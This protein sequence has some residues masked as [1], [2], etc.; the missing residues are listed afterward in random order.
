M[1]NF[2]QKVVQKEGFET[3]K[4]LK[5]SKNRANLIDLPDFGAADRT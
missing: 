2:V 1:K 4:L 5:T 3:E